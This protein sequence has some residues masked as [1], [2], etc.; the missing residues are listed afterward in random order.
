MTRV[1]A[2]PRPFDADALRPVALTVA[3]RS[4]DVFCFLT[5]PLAV[6]YHA[7]ARSSGSRVRSAAAR[8]PEPASL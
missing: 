7:W 4:A 5:T 6:G 2:N 8:K 1:S 3:E